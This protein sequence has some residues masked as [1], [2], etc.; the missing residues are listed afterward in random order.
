MGFHQFTLLFQ[1][2]FAAG[3]GPWMPAAWMRRWLELLAWELETQR[4]VLPYCYGADGDFGGAATVEIGGERWSL[5]LGAG[6]CSLSHSVPA[7]SEAPP[8]PVRHRLTKWLDLRGNRELQTDAGIIKLSRRKQEFRWYSELP[9]V[10]EFLGGVPLE[11]EVR[12][13]RADQ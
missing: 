4:S 13:S 5:T 12:A 11:M 9:G 6:Q 2:C 10:L 7:Q 1:C 8:L 3:G